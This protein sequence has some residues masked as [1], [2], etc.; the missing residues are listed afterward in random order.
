MPYGKPKKRRI[1]KLDTIEVSLVDE[2]AN[3]KDFHI[4][5]GKNNMDYGELASVLKGF[6]LPELENFEQTITDIEKASGKTIPK[7]TQALVKTAM[8]LLQKANDDEDFLKGMNISMFSDDGKKSIFVRKAVEEGEA[9][10]KSDHEA[11]IAKIKKDSTMTPEEKKEIEQ[12]VRSEYT[13]RIEKAL[14]LVK[15]DEL[16]GHIEKALGGADVQIVELSK[17]AM[18]R[19]EKAEAD[20]KLA[21]ERSQK[22]EDENEKNTFIKKSADMTN[23]GSDEKIGTLLYKCSKGLEKEDYNEVERILKAANA[24]LETS[25]LFL[26]KGTN[27]PEET[28]DGEVE[29]LVIQKRKD[30][31]ELTQHQAYCEVMDENQNL[32]EKVG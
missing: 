19:I 1:K 17:A 7:N 21:N 16:K 28:V 25:G 9:V 4:L 6:E 18:E 2:G 12:G 26:E 24:Q 13:S 10:S 5:K 3:G 8:S 20:T 30:K 29:T 22:L 11:E 15:D 31:P 23:I 27:K 32:Y 14:T